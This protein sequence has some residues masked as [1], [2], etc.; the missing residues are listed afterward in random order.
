MTVD[1]HSPFQYW[2]TQFFLPLIHSENLADENREVAS[3]QWLQA[4]AEWARKKEKEEWKAICGNRKM[5]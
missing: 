1:N 3:Y 2:Y 4:H 5:F